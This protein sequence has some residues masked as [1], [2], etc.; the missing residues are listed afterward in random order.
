M[1]NKLIKALAT[2]SNSILLVTASDLADFASD[3]VNKT[4]SEM[5]DRRKNEVKDEKNYFTAQ[6]VCRKIGVSLPTLWRWANAGYLQPIK[7]GTGGKKRR[8][9]KKSDVEKILSDSASKL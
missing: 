3:C 1:E 2:G 4:I 6:E 8:L 9:F 7:V 5:E